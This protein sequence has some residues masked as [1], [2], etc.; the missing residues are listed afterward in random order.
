MGHTTSSVSTFIH[1]HPGTSRK[2]ELGSMG[3]SHIEKKYIMLQNQTWVIKQMNQLIKIHC[4]IP[5]FLNPA[6]CGT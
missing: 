6:M 1:S 5:I 2:E 4:T 3:F